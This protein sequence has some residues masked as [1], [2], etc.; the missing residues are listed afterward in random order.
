MAPPA[1]FWRSLGIKCVILLTILMALAV[2][3]T[4]M[5]WSSL[6]LYFDIIMP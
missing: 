4:G 1:G 2:R 6:C 3:K 5:N